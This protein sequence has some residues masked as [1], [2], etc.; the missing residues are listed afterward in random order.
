MGTAIE[1]R[2]VSVVRDGVRILDSVDLVI[3]DN[4]NVAILGPNG[5][6]KTTLM[7]L[8]RGDILPYSSP[9]TVFRLFGKDRWDLFELRNRIGMVSMDLQSGFDPD[10]TVYDVIMSGFFGSMDVYRNHRIGTAMDEKVRTIGEMM[11]IS[12]KMT[13]LVGTVS[14]GEMRRTLISRALVSGPEML[15]LDEPMTGLDVSMRTRFRNM[16]GTLMENGI[17]IIMI[18]HDLEDIPEGVDRVVMVKNGKI[19][20]DGRKNELLTDGNVSRLYDTDVRVGCRGGTYHMY[21]V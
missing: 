20:A 15:V 13:R 10:S 3:G 19:F 17:N 12:D 5:S 18:T 8:F 1:M 9:E 14:L 21:G 4:E 6:G 16:F 11:G 2:N 7:R